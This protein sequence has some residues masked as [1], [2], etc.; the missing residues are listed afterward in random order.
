MFATGNCLLKRNVWFSRK[1]FLCNRRLTEGGGLGTPSKSLNTFHAIQSIRSQAAVVRI[2]FSSEVWRGHQVDVFRSRRES[3]THRGFLWLEKECR[4][5]WRGD[6]DGT[7]CFTVVFKLSSKSAK[8]CIFKIPKY[9]SIEF[10]LPDVNFLLPD[11]NYHAARGRCG[12]NLLL[13]QL[14][15]QM[16]TRK[17]F[18]VIC[19]LH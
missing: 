11:V 1:L 6:N 15:W 10:L 4:R 7:A 9:I 13:P 18:I 17:T 16:H 8:L 5:L 2:L 12:G 14:G 19:A 3:C